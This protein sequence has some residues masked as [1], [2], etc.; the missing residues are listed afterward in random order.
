MTLPFIAPS[1]RAQA[2][3]I[4]HTAVTRFTDIPEKWL[5]A[6]KQMTVHYAHTSHGMQII[7]GLRYIEENLNAEKYKVA[8]V[9]YYAEYPDPLSA[10]PAKENP[11]AL[12][13]ADTGRKPEGYWDSEAGFQETRSFAATGLYNYS[14]FGWCGELSGSLDLKQYI[15]K[16]LTALDS[17]EREFPSMRF[18]Y[19]TAPTDGFP[20]Y[21]KLRQNNE[22]IRQYCMAHNKILFDFAD[23]ESWDPEGNY[24]P[25][26]YACSWCEDWCK[27][28][29]EECINLPEDCNSGVPTCCPHTHGYNCLIKGKAFWYMMA[30]LAGWDGNITV[31]VELQKFQGH[32]IEEGI[33]LIW[34]T[35]SENNNYGFE[36]ERSY[37]ESGQYQSIGFV[38]GQGTSTLSNH[39]MFIDKN[40]KQG[41]YH[42]RLKQIDA[43]GEYQYIG[44]LLISL[45]PL[46]TLSLW[47]NYP[48]PFNSSTKISYTL[49]RNDFVELTIYD[50]NHCEI[51][52][53]VNEFQNAG[54]YQ[55][56]W[57]AKRIPSGIYYCRLK[58]GDL[59]MTRSMLIVK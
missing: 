30:R 40:V 51:E 47:Q 59:I 36:I 7:S 5:N 45:T 38:F 15:E 25:D 2:L 35:A 33:K 8:Y 22:Q 12:R 20:A 53:L 18:I 39:Y 43:N 44:E 57:Y 34:Q 19:F 6:A 3:K 27:N 58:F 23:I 55:V 48:N 52:S 50:I 56:N 54:T 46:K 21:S 11:P 41:S 16:Y 28:H 9:T 10:L 13:I 17:L 26:N 49:P 24:Y 42:Y 4:D 31:P 1:A 32:L 37:L 29:P 14:M